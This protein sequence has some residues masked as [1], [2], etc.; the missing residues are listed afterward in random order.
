M[1]AIT[2]ITRSVARPPRCALSGH[3]QSYAAILARIAQDRGALLWKIIAVDERSA[4]AAAV[5]LR[6]GDVLRAHGQMSATVH[7]ARDGTPRPSLV[8][9]ATSVERLTAL[10]S[11]H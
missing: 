1:S 10:P 9:F 5:G 8:L 6:E 11:S 4:I 7:I 3:R 2:T